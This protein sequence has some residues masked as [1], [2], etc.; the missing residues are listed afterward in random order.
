ML[1]LVDGCTHYRIKMFRRAGEVE[2]RLVGAGQPPFFPWRLR[3][4]EAWE[5]STGRAEIEAQAN[6]SGLANSPE[7]LW[8]G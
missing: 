3:C 6:L 1:P 8:I 7:D 4:P 2:I 5:S